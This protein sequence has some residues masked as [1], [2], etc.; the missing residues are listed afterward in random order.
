MPDIIKLLPDAIANQIAAGEVV[1]RPASAVKELMENAID[2][3]ATKIQLIVRE[4]GKSLI[5]VIDDGCGMSEMDARMAFER[6]ATSKISNINDLFTLQSMGFRG[7]AMA[8]IAAIAQVELKTRRAIDELGTSIT[9]EGS[10]VIAQNPCQHSVGTSVAIKNLFYNVPARRQFLKS[11]S[12]EL[13]HII[14]EF[15]HIAIAYPLVQFNLVSQDEE[16]YNL[17]PGNLK[18]RLVA[19]LGDNFQERIIPVDEPTD[20][21][22]VTGYV[23]K[24]EAA[25]KTRGDQYFF[26]NNRYIKSAYLNHAVTNAYSDLIPK[27]VFPI[28]AIFITI[29]PAK[30]DVNVH[31]TKQEIKFD[32]ERTVYNLLLASVKK[33]IGI[34]CVAP[35]IDFEQEPGISFPNLFGKINNNNGTHTTHTESEYVKA[36]YPA[37]YTPPSKEGYVQRNWRELYDVVPDGQESQELILPSRFNIEPQTNSEQLVLD[38]KLELQPLQIHRRY[39]I[40]QIKSGFVLVDQQAAHERIVYERLMH[41]RTEQAV[42]TQKLM[43]PQTIT[44][45]AAEAS[46]LDEV[47]PVIQSMGYELEKLGPLDFILYGVPADSQAPENIDE[48]IQNFIEELKTHSGSLVK[49]YRDTSARAIARLVSIKHGKKLKDEEMKTLIEELFACE[50]PYI[51]PSGRL[52]FTTYSLDDINKQFNP[53]R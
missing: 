53:K 7:E 51:S 24:P 39:F 34:Y 5:L 30:I 12:V 43:F 17:R 26:V 44:V 41:A 32:D 10:K 8:S 20:Y 50:V 11:N 35:M 33:A 36:S 25:K 3:G 47:L 27:E 6:H 42:V 21:I 15:L 31:P 13:R 1:Q 52:T 14:D 16:L 28:Y 45:N 49:D 40:Y 22:S 37:S 29:N 38:D 4:A 46:L 48:V 2:A 9:I 19:I 18:Q 23:G